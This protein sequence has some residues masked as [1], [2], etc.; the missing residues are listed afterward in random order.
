[1]VYSIL[2]RIITI[3]LSRWRR[4]RWPILYNVYLFSFSLSENDIRLIFHRVYWINIWFQKLVIQRVK[5]SISKWRAIT[6]GIW[7]R[8][9]LGKHE[10]V[11]IF[12]EHN[13]L[14]SSPPYS[15]LSIIYYTLSLHCSPIEISRNGG[16]FNIC[17]DVHYNANTLQLTA[18]R[19]QSELTKDRNRETT[20]ISLV[21]VRLFL[22]LWGNFGCCM[23][24]NLFLPQMKKN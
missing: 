1:M 15:C 7:L 12:S 18:P 23:I 22:Q 10:I 13:F 4:S 21:F 3:M 11:R 20:N 14:F 6:T 2:I 5:S 24:H 17:T 8:S 9:L 16:R 19:S